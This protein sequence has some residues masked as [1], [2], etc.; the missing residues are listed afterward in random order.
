M[1]LVGP[2]PLFQLEGPVMS[3]TITSGA[4]STPP[5]SGAPAPVG[6]P[7]AGSVRRE[8]VVACEVLAGSLEFCAPCA[9]GATI[10]G[11]PTSNAVAASLIFIEDWPFCEGEKSR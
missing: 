5:E 11:A 9:A 1:P 7:G 4:L 2:T 8:S 6:K 3:P 10:H